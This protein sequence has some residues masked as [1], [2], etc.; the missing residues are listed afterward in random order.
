MATWTTNES[1]PV[2]T[3]AF[4]LLIGDG[5]ELLIGD[6]FKLSIQSSS[7]GSDWTNETKT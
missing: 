6:G 2:A 7:Q 5:F 4:M 1:K 3:V